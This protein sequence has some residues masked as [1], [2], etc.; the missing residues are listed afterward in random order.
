MIGIIPEQY[1]SH[2][3]MKAVDNQMDTG[4]ESAYFGLPKF[5]WFLRQDLLQF[6]CDQSISYDDH[7]GNSDQNTWG[8]NSFCNGIFTTRQR[9][10]G[11]VIFSYMSVS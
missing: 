2:A 1:L 7:T 3:I 8:R 11:K 6:W 5:T 9:S 4:L 10:S